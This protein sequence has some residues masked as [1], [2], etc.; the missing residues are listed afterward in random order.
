[1]R[2]FALNIIWECFEDHFSKLWSIADLRFIDTAAKGSLRRDWSLAD[3]AIPSANEVSSHGFFWLPPGRLNGELR[4]AEALIPLNQY[5][6][7][8]AGSS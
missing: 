7:P 8:Y 4:R 3:R 2:V 5:L 6:L 1:M